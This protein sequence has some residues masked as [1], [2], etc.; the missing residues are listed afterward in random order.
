MRPTH[1]IKDLEITQH[2]SEPLQPGEQIEVCGCG[3]RGKPAK[4][5]MGASCPLGMPWSCLR[6]MLLPF[7][8][9]MERRKQA[10]AGE[11]D[12]RL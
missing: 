7:E 10:T 12:P 5:S 11:V 3:M 1:N 8:E 9:P 2:I 6:Q 4:A